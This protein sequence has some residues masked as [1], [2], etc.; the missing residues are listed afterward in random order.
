M[1]RNN[2]KEKRRKGHQ[3]Q[4][5]SIFFVSHILSSYMRRYLH[6]GIKRSTVRHIVVPGFEAIK[7][8]QST[9]CRLRKIF[10]NFEFEVNCCVIWLPGGIASFDNRPILFLRKQDILLH[11]FLQKKRLLYRQHP[12]YVSLNGVSRWASL[13]TLEAGALWSG[14]HPLQGSVAVPVCDIWFP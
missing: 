3:K 14:R 13:G 11:S 5:S 6:F 7:T 8:V 10:V 1:F 2:V 9:D 12:T 4:C